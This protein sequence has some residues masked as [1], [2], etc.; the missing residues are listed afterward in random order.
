MSATKNMTLRVPEDLFD[1]IVTAKSGSTTQ[2]V[3]D[4]IAEKLRRDEKASVIAGLGGLA[5][6]VLDPDL[7]AAQRRTMRHAD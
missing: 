4:A 1:Q 2:F 6:D 5:G 3:L 7:N